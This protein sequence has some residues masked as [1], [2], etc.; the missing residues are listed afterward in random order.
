MNNK[1]TKGKYKS[2]ITTADL[3][4]HYNKGL[5]KV[6]SITGEKTKG[7][8]QITETEYSTILKDIN[9]EII[10]LIIL[11]NFEFKIPC[12]LGYLSMKQSK[13]QYLLDENGELD[14]K[15]LSVDYK[16]T[17]ELWKNNEKAK[18]EKKL[19]FYT[20]EHTNGYRMSYW[21]SKRGAWT[22]GI[23]VYYFLPCRK[24]KR[25]P[26]EFLKN[27]EFGLTFYEKINNKA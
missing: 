14:T 21:W 19:L 24:V 5:N 8:F 16:A 13:I 15:N 27:K 10:K 4:K 18:L 6:V 11:D 22:T 1:R 23:A 26:V 25:A 7:S 3:Y 17:N 2:D 12:G 20:N 9:D